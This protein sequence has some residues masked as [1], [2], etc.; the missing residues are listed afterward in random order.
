[1]KKQLLV[2]VE[3]P[4]D[5]TANVFMDIA[6]KSVLNELNADLDKGWAVR[7]EDIQPQ[8]YSYEQLKEFAL[9]CSLE[10]HLCNVDDLI[11]DGLTPA[12]ILALVEK[13]SA[14]VVITEEYEYHPREDVVESIEG[15]RGVNLFQ[16]YELLTDINGHEWFINFKEGK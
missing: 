12:D 4:N 5:T 11:T 8:S 13:G 6:I 16:F 14:D 10:H 2:T 9:K 1:M 3:Y 7:H 15:I